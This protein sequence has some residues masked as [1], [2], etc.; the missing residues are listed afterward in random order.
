MSV[1]NVIEEFV[2]WLQTPQGKQAIDAFVVVVDDL[3]GPDD[4]PA[5]IQP[6]AAPNAPVYTPPASGAPVPK[7]RRANLPSTLGMKK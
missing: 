1:R 6:K 3:L 4:I 2:D 5:P 7:V